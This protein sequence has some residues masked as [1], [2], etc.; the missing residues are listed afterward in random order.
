MGI[1]IGVGWN[2]VACGASNK[3]FLARGRHREEQMAPASPLQAIPR[4]PS[5]VFWKLPTSVAALR[6]GKRRSPLFQ[7]KQSAPPRKAKLCRPP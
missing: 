4:H 1:G 5:A 7:P 3:D 2:Q 6:E